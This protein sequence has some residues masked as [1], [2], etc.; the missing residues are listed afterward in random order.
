[1]FE[2]K[3]C[4][5]KSERLRGFSNHVY[6]QHGIKCIDYFEKY[7]KFEIPKCKCGK[8]RLSRKGLIFG[9]TCGND[10]C[11]KEY[12]SEA[13]KISMGREEVRQK[14]RE[15]RLEFLKSNPEQTAWRLNYK[16]QSWPE[17]FFEEGC[18][19]YGLDTKY[20]IIKEFCV[21]PYYIDFA[22]TDIKIA[23]E[24]DGSQHNLKDRKERDIKKDNLLNAHGWRVYR[25][26]AKLLYDNESIEDVFNSFLE[27]ISNEVIINSNCAGIISATDKKKLQKEEVRRIKNEKIEK[28]IADK[29]EKLL[30]SKIDFSKH[31]WVTKAS[32]VLEISPQKVNVWMKRNMIDFYNEK[33]FVRTA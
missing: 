16:N 2:C 26:E 14:L 15:R 3:I 20:E 19:K 11:K 31:G 21:F 22:F 28:S 25:I 9:K 1:M 17:K 6:M 23:V 29:K 8:N 24:I 30:L 13:Q 18:M 27:F 12:N 4:E 10:K 32:A 33:C 7:E 5:Y